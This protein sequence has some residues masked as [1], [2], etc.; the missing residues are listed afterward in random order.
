MK[1]HVRSGMV[2]ACIMAIIA[3]GCGTDGASSA[4]GQQGAADVSRNARDDASAGTASTDTGDRKAVPSFTAEKARGGTLRSGQLQAPAVIQFFA[5][6]C[7]TCGNSAAALAELQQK[8]PDLA[9][10]LVAVEDTPGRAQA[11]MDE[12]KWTRGELINDPDRAMQKRFAL[13]GQPNTVFVHDDRTFTAHIG[14][15]EYEQL[16]TKVQAML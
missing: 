9:Y 13:V 5:S 1:N 3:A 8:Y 4:G 15:S 12:H 14:P 11:F 16:R 10:Y 6:W 7:T 2:L